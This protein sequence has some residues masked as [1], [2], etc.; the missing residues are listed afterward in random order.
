MFNNVGRIAVKL[1]VHDGISFVTMILPIC[2]KTLVVRHV[3]SNLF[4]VFF[5]SIIVIILD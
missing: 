4:S 1:N 2:G 5:F 3:I